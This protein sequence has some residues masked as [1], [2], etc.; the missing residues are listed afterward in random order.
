MT[1][2]CL[3]DALLESCEPIAVALSVLPES[4]L[5]PTSSRRHGIRMSSISLDTGLAPPGE[6]AEGCQGGADSWKQ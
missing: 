6:V 3:L 2:V 5:L 1:R 4:P